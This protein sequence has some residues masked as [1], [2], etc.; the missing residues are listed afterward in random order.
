V[1]GIE[2][3]VGGSCGAFVVWMGEIVRCLV[4]GDPANSSTVGDGWIIEDA[5]MDGERIP[6]VVSVVLG[7][8][9][10][11]GFV[12]CSQYELELVEADGSMTISGLEVTERVCGTPAGSADET[13]LAAIR[14]LTTVEIVDDE[15][16]LSGPGVELRFRR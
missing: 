10:I 8:H 5:V 1:T 3:H 14:R 9:S 4:G 12:P 16:L 6:V 11:S 2:V 7:E 15:M 13:Y